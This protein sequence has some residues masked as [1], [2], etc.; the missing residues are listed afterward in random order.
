M[1]CGSIIRLRN[2]VTH[3]NLRST[4]GV[5]STSS[6][7][8]QQEVSHS[9]SSGFGNSE[10]NWKVMCEPAKS[11]AYA[12]NWRSFTVDK[13]LHKS[14][15]DYALKVANK[16]WLKTTVFRLRHVDTGKLLSF[17]E[18]G[19]SQAAC[20]DTCV[21]RDIKLPVAID[22]DPSKDTTLPFDTSLRKDILSQPNCLED[23]AMSKDDTAKPQHCIMNGH[24]A[25]PTA[26]STQRDSVRFFT[27]FKDP[28]AF[29]DS[30]NG[31]MLKRFMRSPGRLAGDL[32]N[33]V[34]WR[35]DSSVPCEGKGPIVVGQ[36]HKVIQH[37]MVVIVEKW[38]CMNFYLERLYCSQSPD[39]V[40]YTLPVTQLFGP[41]AVSYSKMTGVVKGVNVTLEY[42]QENQPVLRHDRTGND[43]AA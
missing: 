40:N 14:R 21:K 8:H 27:K 2:M 4:G 18:L 28:L 38:D 36:V 15:F 20:G 30:S 26:V 1:Q 12:S 34:S 42:S 11:H 3:T 43:I 24:S 29:H 17:S 31:V 41:L 35:M 33:F 25:L 13:A 32:Q 10:D 5:Y 9:F 6:H 23:A 7:V 22:F 16:Y 39:R 19:I 37:A